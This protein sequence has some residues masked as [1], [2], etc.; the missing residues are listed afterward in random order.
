M[1]RIFISYRR[2]DSAAHAGRLYDRLEGHFG[3]QNV[4]MDVDTIQPGLD[5]VDVV[6]E[7]VASCDVLIAVIG[8][9]WLEVSDATGRRRLDNPE[10]L[11]RLE[12]AT[13]LDRNI[14]VIPL[15]VQGVR[16]PGSTDLPDALKPLARR[17]AL[18]LSDTRFRSDVDRLIEVLQAPQSEVSPSSAEDQWGQPMVG[19]EREWEILRSRLDDVMQG[20]GGLV[21]ITGEAGIGKTRLAAELRTYAGAQG[22]QWLEGRYEKEGSIPLQPY[23]EAVRTYLRTA[24]LDSLTALV[25]PYSAELGRAFPELDESLGTAPLAAD[26]PPED[27]EAA[28]QRH[29]EAI[30]HLFINIARQTPL[31]LFLDDLQWAPSVDVVQTLARRASGEPLLVVGA[32]RDAELREKPSLSRAVLTMSRNHLFQSLPLRRL[33]QAEVSQLVAGALAQASSEEVVNLVYEHTDG[34]PFFAEELARYLVESGALVLEEQGWQIQDMSSVQMPDS[35]KLVVEERLERLEEETRR[36]LGMASVIGQE[37]SLALLQEVTGTDEEA[38]VDA[39]DQAVEARLLVPRSRVGQ[40]VY[41]FADNQV[42]EVLYHGTGT[43]R[44]RRYHRRV[45]EAIEKVHGRRLEEHYGALAHHFL[46]GNDLEKAVDYSIKA[47]DLAYNQSS[48]PRARSHYQVAAELLEELDDRSE[49]SAH[50]HTQLGMDLVTGSDVQHIRSALEISVELGNIRRAASLYRTLGAAYISG[51]GVDQ[52]YHEALQHY[53]LGVDLLADGDDGLEKAIAY[54]GLAFCY[55]GGF[56]LDRAEELARET[57]RIAEAIQDQDAMTLAFTELGLVLAQKGHLHESFSYTEQ[58][59][60]AAQQARTPRFRQRAA[61]YPIILYPWLGDGTH[62]QNWFARWEE[63]QREGTSQRY[64]GSV[65]SV[66]SS[67]LVQMGDPEKGREF[68]DKLAGLDQADRSYRLGNAQSMVA[69]AILGDWDAVQG[70]L[71]ALDWTGIGNSRHNAIRIAHHYGQ[72]LLDRDQHQRCE[73]LLRPQ[74]EFCRERGGVIYEVNLL[75][76]LGESYLLLNRL[77]EAHTCLERAR[78]IMDRS[79]NWGGL[80]AGVSSLEALLGA[81]EERWPEAESAFQQAVETNERHGLLYDQ[82]RAMF[83]WGVMHLERDTAGDR[84]RGTELLDQSLALFQRC[85]AKKDIERVII[86]KEQLQ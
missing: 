44:R 3:Q 46:E 67:V 12:I 79:E 37:F 42:R 81:V 73:E 48:F 61:T 22:C 70:H 5:F 78:E 28:R 53:Q 64:E 8:R 52:D 82:A 75:P 76:L 40:E 10:D 41:A 32:Y 60:L 84:E 43:A 20:H 27:Q 54:E 68:L 51:T 77:E 16:E 72:F 39:V 7:A 49:R 74:W 69:Q 13:A 57:L 24:P 25:G 30:S 38:H 31:V 50:V 66:M 1:P 65:L 83:K 35:V 34:N 45:G 18:E 80:A 4:F 26:P 55:H 9:E 19:R 15:L 6:R 29:L 86:R 47:G 36:T 71:A 56:E 59:W 33:S 23:V 21:F 63:L 62:C 11:V 2:D 14:R 17:N 58:A 85:D